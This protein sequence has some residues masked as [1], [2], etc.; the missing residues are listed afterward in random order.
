[1]TTLTAAEML[2]VLETL[3]ANQ[4]ARPDLRPQAAIDAEMRA[5]QVAEDRRRMRENPTD[6]DS[7]WSARRWA[8]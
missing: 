1:M 3:T 7:E 8:G 5:E 4:P 2:H 6:G